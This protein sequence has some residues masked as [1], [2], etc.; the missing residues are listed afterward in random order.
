MNFVRNLLLASQSSHIHHLISK[1]KL[2]NISILTPLP[3][4]LSSVRNSDCCIN[5]AVSSIDH[6][7]SLAA[8]QMGVVSLHYYWYIS[9]IWIDFVIIMWLCMYAVPDCG[10]KYLSIYLSIINGTTSQKS[11][12]YILSLRYVFISSKNIFSFSKV[13]LYLNG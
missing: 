4:G 7:V 6:A 11:R 8:A 2:W 13:S 5:T 12:L 9:H 1:S 3:L 10:I